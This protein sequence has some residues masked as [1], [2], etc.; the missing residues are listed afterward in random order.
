LVAAHLD[1]GL[2]EESADRAQRAESLAEELGIE[3]L[4]QRLTAP[5]ASSMPRGVEDWARSERYEFL[6]QQRR[7][8]HLRYIATG[9]H[10]DDQIETVLIRL[11][12]GSGLEGLA[13][14]ES[15]RGSIVRP[16]LRFTRT[17]IAE[18]LRQLGLTTNADI[19]NQDLDRPR[20]LVRRHLLPHLTEQEPSAPD[21]ILS[22]AATA[23]RA[24][25]TIRSRLDEILK[26]REENDGASIELDQLR[27]LP[28]PLHPIALAQLHRAA[29]LPY[30][31]G[32]L[33]RE[34]LARQLSRAGEIGCDCG[35]GWFWQGHEG[36]LRLQPRP[37][38]A[39][40][41]T[42]TLKVPGVLDIPEIGVRFSL[43][44]EPLAPWMFEGRP[45]RAAL[46]LPVSN[47]DEITVRSRCPGDRIQPL[48]CPYSRRLKEVLIDRHMPRTQRD[49]LPLLCLGETVAWVP[50]VTI[51]E[52]YRISS[53][54]R[55]WVARIEPLA[56]N[57]HTGQTVV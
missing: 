21:R 50:G 36:R 43:C 28:T 45:T 1:H 2:D 54:S 3:F 26:L 34:E 47:G 13:A 55:P 22:L 20:N 8:H 37:T 9:H 53:D 33:A 10:R 38:P 42:Y 29:S 30:P 23:G 24:A 4:T 40:R 19:T 35:D 51:D 48:G 14:M 12:M 41:F 44:R 15:R 18:R 17:E 52:D 11:L 39:Q 6:E 7:R 5:T 25:G 49:R 32:R 27:R 57:A 56:G 46:D 31:P 16:L